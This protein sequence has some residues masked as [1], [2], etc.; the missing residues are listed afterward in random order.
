MSSYRQSIYQL[1]FGTK[2]RQKTLTK[3]ADRDRL[4]AYMAQTLRQ[5]NCFVY[6]VNGV[7]D[8]VHLLFSLHPTVAMS[9]LIRDVKTSSNKFIKTSLD[10]PKFD[11]WQRGYG[12]F[13]YAPE[14][15]PNLK[16]YVA[17]QEEHHGLVTFETEYIDLLEEH[18]VEY[19]T[20]YLFD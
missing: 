2:Y 18:E 9:N 13:T 15:L 10:L 19:D 3:K 14:A 6:D 11:R 16:A 20:R 1:V 12:Y 4:W 17:R 5:M 8:H 7:E